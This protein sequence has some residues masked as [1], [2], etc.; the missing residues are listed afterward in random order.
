MLLLCRKYRRVLF[1]SAT[2]ALGYLC[3]GDVYCQQGRSEA[4]MAGRKSVIYDKGLEAVPA[5]DP[6]YRD[7]QQQRQPRRSKKTSS[8]NKR[9]DFIS[10][11]PID[12]VSTY[13]IP[14][15]MPVLLSTGCCPYLQVSHTWQQRILQHAEDLSVEVDYELDSFREGHYQLFRIAPYVKSLDIIVRMQKN[16]VDLF[17]RAKFSSLKKL[18]LGSELSE[19]QLKGLA[20]V[21]DTLTHLEVGFNSSL[22]LL[23]ILRTCPN[24][25]FLKTKGVDVVLPSSSSSLQYPRLTHLGL[26]SW[27]PVYVD[28]E[29]LLGLFPKLVWFE[30]SPMPE[31]S[32]VL[33]VLPQQCPSLRT[34]SYG[35]EIEEKEA[36]RIIHVKGRGITVARLGEGDMVVQ[37][38]LIKFLSQHHQTLKELDLDIQVFNPEDYT[39][40]WDLADGKLIHYGTVVPMSF[41][42]LQ[43]LRVADED[44]YTLPCLQWILENAPQLESISIPEPLFIRDTARGLKKLKHLKKL[45]VNDASGL[46]DGRVIGPLLQHHAALG[47]RSTL[48]HIQVNFDTYQLSDV[49][50]LPFVCGLKKLKKL[51]LFADYMMGDCIP[52]LKKLGK[53]CPSLDELMLGYGGANFEGGLITALGTHPN[54]RSLYIGAH[55]LSEHEL[56]CLANFPKLERVYLYLPPSDSLRDYLPKRIQLIY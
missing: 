49:A 26:H 24:L 45:H 41:P 4:A 37:D 43:T 7:L 27:S 52:F 30:I 38:D 56:R 55:A 1:R 50:W 25:T 42:V 36:K 28:I 14:R 11:L 29:N 39:I 31:G 35:R 16:L 23:D 44:Y 9:I 22:H 32:S 8:N 15:F 13:I 18:K 33:H 5:S 47:D 40:P 21:A 53:G 3:E 48:E 51:D 34:L 12:V 2:A 19:P 10:E 6:H 54:L 17:T 46:V 20:M